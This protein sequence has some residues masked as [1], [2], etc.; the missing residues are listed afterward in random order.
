MV[1]RTPKA[2]G[3]SGDKHSPPP[4]TT[5]AAT[6]HDVILAAPTVTVTWD[7]VKLSLGSPTDDARGMYAVDETPEERLALGRRIASAKI[8]LIAGSQAA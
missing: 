2:A 4:A 3:K 5:V 8:R 7:G 6:P 1:Q